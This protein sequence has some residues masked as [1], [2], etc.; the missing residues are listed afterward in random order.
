MERKRSDDLSLSLTLCFIFGR[1]EEGPRDPESSIRVDRAK[2]ASC[3]GDYSGNRKK[4]K[5]LAYL[6]IDRIGTHTDGS[7]RAGSILRNWIHRFPPVALFRSLP[8]FR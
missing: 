3:N 1:R 5:R 6:L 2:I 7:L 4:K 8:N